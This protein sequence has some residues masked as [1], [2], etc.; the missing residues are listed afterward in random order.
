MIVKKIRAKSVE[1]LKLKIPKQENMNTS[2]KIHIEKRGKLL[3]KTAILNMNIIVTMK[4]IMMI[5]IR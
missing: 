2:M 1:K 5:I 3:I 4:M